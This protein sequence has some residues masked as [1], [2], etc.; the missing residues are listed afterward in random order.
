MLSA[1]ELTHGITQYEAGLDYFSE[2]G[3]LNESWSDAMGIMIKQAA[4]KQSVED[5]N[6]LLGEG[7]LLKAPALRSLKNPSF[8]NNQ[9][10]HMSEFK[11]MTLDSGGV[12]INSGI[13]NKA[14]YLTAVYK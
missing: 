10:E 5:S 6:W 4:L 7:L 13:P 8:R 3:A 14:F 12:H 9:P 1:H 2:S 11:A